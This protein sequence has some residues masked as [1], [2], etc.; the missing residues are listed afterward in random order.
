VTSIE[1]CKGEGRGWGVV[2]WQSATHAERQGGLTY[3]GVEVPL[4]SSELWTLDG[5]TGNNVG[6][7][8]GGVGG[9]FVVLSF[10]GTLVL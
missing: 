8:E 9:V 2:L 1:L 6:G 5:G 4:E 3:S 10:R 7:S